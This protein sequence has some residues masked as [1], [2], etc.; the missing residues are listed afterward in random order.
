[1]KNQYVYADAVDRGLAGV[2]RHFN[3]DGSLIDLDLAN[4]QQVN[5]YM[6]MVDGQRKQ[7]MRYNRGIRMHRRWQNS[8]FVGLLMADLPRD[9]K[10][11]R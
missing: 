2:P 9:V 5:A 11:I 4:Q 6:G 1:M 7:I 8:F 3:A 10:T